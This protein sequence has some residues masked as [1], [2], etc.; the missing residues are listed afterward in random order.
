MRGLV[1][2]ISRGLFVFALL[3]TPLPAFSADLACKVVG[4]TDGD[5]LTCLTQEKRQIKVRLAQI[6]APEKAQPFGQRAKQALSDLVFGKQVMLERETT[7][8]YGRMVAKVIKDSQDINL[9]MVRAGMA[10]VY[11]QYAHDQHYFS[12]QEVARTARAGLWADENPVRPS[13]WRN[14]GRIETIAAAETAEPA[15]KQ[16]SRFSCEGKSKCGQMSSCAE[17]RFYLTQCGVSRL[18]RDHD[19][20]P[21][22]SICK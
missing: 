4:V 1:V 13:E 9:D 15:K 17:A 16:K 14:G 5:T 11:D 6:D 2:V 12:V 21:C 20:V 10:W 7:D 8:R 3:L 19:G 22:E 18:D